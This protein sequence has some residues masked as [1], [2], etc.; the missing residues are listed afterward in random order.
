M[1]STPKTCEGYALL[2]ASPRTVKMFMWQADLHGIA[3]FYLLSA[4]DYII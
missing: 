3:C 1:R 4:S 2:F